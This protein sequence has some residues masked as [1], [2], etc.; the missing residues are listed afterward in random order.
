M[1]SPTKSHEEAIQK[2][3]ENQGKIAQLIQLK[4]LGWLAGN[5]ARQAKTDQAERN[6]YMKQMGEPSGGEDSEAEDEMG[7]T[8]LGDI[9][10]PQPV[11]ISPPQSNL[12]PIA[13]LAL[14]AAIPATGAIGVAGYLSANRDKQPAAVTHPGF[15][16]STVKIGLGRIED[17]D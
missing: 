15:D 2:H 12:L 6:W 10:H 3:L 9:N 14:A 7:T 11:V 1:S 17:L 13:L 8:I 16:D 4:A 5:E